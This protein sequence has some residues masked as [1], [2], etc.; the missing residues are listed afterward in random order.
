MYVYTYVNVHCNDR[1]H[2]TLAYWHAI[3][4]GENLAETDSILNKQKVLNKNFYLS[5]VICRC[6]T[7]LNCFVNR[8]SL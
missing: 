3:L 5:R 2:F 8:N 4:R 6:C 1:N 7:N